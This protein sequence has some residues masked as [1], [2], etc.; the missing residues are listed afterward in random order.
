MIRLVGQHLYS[1]V[2]L[3]KNT[4]AFKLATRHIVLP[5]KC[6]LL[7]A[8]INTKITRILYLTTAAVLVLTVMSS[9]FPTSQAGSG[10]HPYFYLLSQ[11]YLL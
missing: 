11:F 10:K 2:L 9:T 1:T 8:L 3:Y 5:P 4:W 7:M 6:F